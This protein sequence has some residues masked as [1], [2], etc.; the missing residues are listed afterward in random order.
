MSQ[1]DGRRSVVVT[2]GGR[3]IGHGIGHGIGTACVFAEAGA[4]VLLPEG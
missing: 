3:G 4:R 1:L 2:G